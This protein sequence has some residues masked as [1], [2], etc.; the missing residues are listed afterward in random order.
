MKNKR[1]HFST[2]LAIAL[3]IL[4]N[5]H[6]YA[7]QKFEFSLW[8]N[9]APNTNGIVEQ[10]SEARAN[11]P[12]NIT[13][14]TLTVYVAKNSNGKAI[15]ACP[16]G[17]Y[18]HLAM[19]HEGHDMA[20]WFNAQGI[21]YAVLKYRMPNEHHEVPLSDALQAIRLVREHA[22]EWNID[23][24]KIAT[25]GFSAGGHLCGCLGTLFDGAEISGIGT[26]AQ[27]RPDILGLCYPVAVS[28]GRTHEGSFQNLT[29]GDPVLRQ[30]LSLEKLVRADMPPVFLWHTRQDASVPCRNSLI[31]AQAMEEAGVDFALHIYRE[32]KHGLS[33]ADAMAFPMYELPRISWDV[34]GWLEACIRFFREVGLTVTDREVQL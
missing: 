7:Q 1:K 30:R 4:G 15:V 12:T 27:L 33:A 34:P 24:D 10:E 31:L 19:D 20:A 13:S 28:W 29:F 16:G 9:G 18:V 8:P 23:P 3:F 5:C 11:R 21:T 6:L 22:E 14:P 25:C 26:A 17:G 32:G 2:V